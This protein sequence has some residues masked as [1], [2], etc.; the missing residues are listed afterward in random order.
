MGLSKSRKGSIEKKLKRDLK[1]RRVSR[2]YR[3][4]KKSVGSG[5]RDGVGL[6][7][8]DKEEVLTDEQIER[9]IQQ[10]LEKTASVPG[11][12]SAPPPPS[13][14]NVKGLIAPTEKVANVSAQA[15]EQEQEQEQPASVEYME[16]GRVAPPEELPEN[17]EAT[18]IPL[19]G[20]STQSN[21]T[22][23]NTGELGEKEEEE[24]A[25]ALAQTQAQPMNSKFLAQGEARPNQKLNNKNTE[26]LTISEPT[27]IGR[28]TI[29]K[30][31]TSVSVPE[32]ELTISEPTLIGRSTVSKP[33]TSVTVPEQESETETDKRSPFEIFIDLLKERDINFLNIFG[34]IFYLS[35]MYGR[36]GSANIKPAL[37]SLEAFKEMFQV[38]DEDLC[39]TI[40]AYAPLFGIKYADFRNQKS[41]IDAGYKLGST[42]EDDEILKTT[43]K[44]YRDL[45]NERARLNAKTQSD[46]RSN[47]VRMKKVDSY[48]AFLEKGEGERVEA[49]EGVSCDV[50]KLEEPAPAQ[51][52]K[53][54]DCKDLK[55]CDE[56]K[57]IRRLLSLLIMKNKESPTPV[58]AY[59]NTPTDD[60]LDEL[61]KLISRRDDDG[62]TDAKADA[63]TSQK[64][65]EIKS[66][67]EKLVEQAQEVAATN[68]DLDQEIKELGAL[69]GQ[70][71]YDIIEIQYILGELKKKLDELQTTDKV[72]A[73]KENVDTLIE[74]VKPA[75]LDEAAI[76]KIV[77]DYLREKYPDVGEK[78]LEEASQTVD[79]AIQAVESG[80]NEKVKESLDQLGSRIDDLSKIMD[81]A[82]ALKPAVEAVKTQ[83]NAG[84]QTENSKDE[85]MASLEE[86]RGQLAELQ[87]KE[88]EKTKAKNSTI[89]DIL[90]RLN[91]AEGRVGALEQKPAPALALA[92]EQKDYSA[93]IDALK[94]AL[95]LSQE[96]SMKAIEDMTATVSSRN[97][98]RVPRAEFEGLK[99]QLTALQA[100][101]SAA[102]AEQL[103]QLQQLNASYSA[104]MEQLENHKVRIEA[105]E[106][107]KDDIRGQM[108]ELISTS[109]QVSGGLSEKLNAL[110]GQLG[111]K[112]AQL[113]VLKGALLAKDT[114]LGNIKGELEKRMGKLEE[115]IMKK[116][117]P[118][119]M[120]E[121]AQEP[122]PAQI[123]EPIQVAESTFETPNPMLA[124]DQTTSQK[125]EK[126]VE[127]KF[128]EDY[129]NSFY[130]DVQKTNRFA[131][132]NPDLISL[133]K[134]NSII[135]QNYIRDIR[136]YSQIF[137]KYRDRTNDTLKTFYTKLID[138]EYNNALKRKSPKDPY[139]SL[140]PAIQTPSQGENLLN[141]SQKIVYGLFNIFMSYIN[142]DVDDIII[143][144]EKEK[145]DVLFDSL[146]SSIGEDNI[147]KIFKLHDIRIENYRDV[148]DK[149]YGN[150]LKGTKIL[151]QTPVA[152]TNLLDLSESRALINKP[153]S[154]LQEKSDTEARQLL[155]RMSPFLQQQKRPF[156][157]STIGGDDTLRMVANIQRNPDMT[158][159]EIVDGMDLNQIGGAISFLKFLEDIYGAATI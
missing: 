80:E 88:E 144:D 9:E 69:V 38:K 152:D 107:E 157:K 12:I 27:L 109:D 129:F 98:D 4:F 124:K 21:Q 149:L 86:L 87:A 151:G 117:E 97:A 110:T 102:T 137:E 141:V 31:I 138:V 49:V 17:N 48:I 54:F 1:K 13:P 148:K 105:L 18:T 89:G 116:P 5:P 108:T 159:E 125:E 83:A 61:L 33:I 153:A 142:I 67:V 39:K 114:K 45:L 121:Q 36:T 119:L 8:G 59:L 95:A 14:Y 53:P 126:K 133:F 3:K 134:K 103:T 130:K 140:K 120:Q 11:P 26:E 46:N 30:P 42:P 29:S 145:A 146:A 91:D 81:D 57:A 37:Y 19:A 115:D 128:L 34:S 43:L 106:A 65:E 22:E 139:S 127:K 60:A 16:T 2:H 99:G 40:K 147:F 28:S 111:D 143:R 56:L 62:A 7:E 24:L 15:Q 136:G 118:A 44:H 85:L 66:S 100:E 55:E 58:D 23:I 122:V 150:Y 96:Q 113:D 74:E 71:V 47:N 35:K 70:Q 82:L 123:E 135:I 79:Q 92:P 72:E 84:Q 90:K 158:D 112:Q 78:K 132:L 20:L 75:A 155:E 25:Q 68:P 104:V 156:K 76:L 93:D 51:A 101:K 77:E 63:D 64:K 6:L 94:A 131:P 32:E 10:G 154:V 41:L 73:L 50:K 52:Q